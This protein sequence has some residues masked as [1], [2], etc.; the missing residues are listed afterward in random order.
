MNLL[1]GRMRFTG[2]ENYTD[3]LSS[4]GFQRSVSLT[5]ALVVISVP[6][7]LAVA[8]FL[9]QLL[10]TERRSARFLRGVFFLPY[11]SSTAAIAVIWSWMFNTDLG[12]IN[13][14]LDAL[15]LD[16]R[17]WLYSPDT[18]LI[19]VALVNAWKQLGYDMVLFIAG[20][21]AISPSLYEAARIDGAKPLKQF[22]TITV[23]LLSP[24]LLF[25][26]VISV[27]DSF[28]IFTL[29][30]VMTGGGPALATDVVV[31]FFYRMGFVRLDYGTASAVVVLLFV[32]LAGLALLKF[33]LFGR[34]VSYDLQ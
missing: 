4:E 6:I 20:L 31:N 11:V 16:R 5:T 18:A 29:V 32:L 23:P 27:I 14:A 22:A 9:A 21:Q 3:L 10:M 33:G 7:R 30:R 2:F 25:L 19:A 17:N 12:L 24:T 34:K 26:L 1:S 28:Q 8:L 15:G 13:A